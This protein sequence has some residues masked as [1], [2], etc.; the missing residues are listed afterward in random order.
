LQESSPYK[1]FLP[2]DDENCQH[3]HNGK[4]HT[5]EKSQGAAISMQDAVIIIRGLNLCGVHRTN[6]LFLMDQCLFGGY[7]KLLKNKI[8]VIIWLPSPI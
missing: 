1:K 4:P 8:S 7:S 3:L 5:K 2:L 6:V